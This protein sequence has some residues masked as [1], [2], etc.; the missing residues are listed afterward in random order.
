MKITVFILFLFLSTQH[1]SAQMSFQQ[2]PENDP[3]PDTF[4]NAEYQMIPKSAVRET[5]GA[6][7]EG[8]AV[9]INDD[10]Y[11]FALTLPYDISF[12]HSQA[13]RALE[14]QGFATL[15]SDISK[16]LYERDFSM[17]IEFPLRTSTFE[18]GAAYFSNS[19]HKDLEA[20]DYGSGVEVRYTFD[21][22]ILST[23][24]WYV[25]LI[26][27]ETLGQRYYIP[28]IGFYQET[29][30]SSVYIDIEFPG[31][32]DLSFYI[33]PDVSLHWQTYFKS[34]SAY[35]QTKHGR[36]PSSILEMSSANSDLS[37]RYHWDELMIFGIGVGTITN[38]EVTLYDRDYD[39]K[40]AT[41]SLEDQT[42]YTVMIAIGTEDLFEL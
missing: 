27:A 26:A 5:A 33:T 14:L 38:R 12:S 4:F 40:I 19:D 20:E 2:Y 31:Y 10:W 9:T 37:L 6:V 17:E 25:G 16:D 36:Y 18:I 28:E 21:T 35:R 1:L 13:H 11:E 15:Q 3:D 42:T 24:S 23:S 29:G 7:E 41:F 39:K 8:S 34:E 22:S 30:E 32:W